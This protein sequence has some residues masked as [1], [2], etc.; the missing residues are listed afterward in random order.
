MLT[1]SKRKNKPPNMYI[2]RPDC[3]GQRMRAIRIFNQFRFWLRC[4]IFDL[5]ISVG[6][7]S[8]GAMV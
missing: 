7:I 5:I 6:L 4:N 3:I 1:A 2:T 8:A